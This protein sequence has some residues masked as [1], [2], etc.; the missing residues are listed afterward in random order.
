MKRT[1]ARRDPDRAPFLAMLAVW[2]FG[3]LVALAFWG[4]VI[5]GIVEVVQWLTSK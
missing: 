1:S 4:V 3:V 2:G 5:W